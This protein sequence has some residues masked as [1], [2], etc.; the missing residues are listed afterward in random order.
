MGEKAFIA[1]PGAQS[2]MKISWGK[3]PLARLD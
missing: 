1:Q 3:V 2:E